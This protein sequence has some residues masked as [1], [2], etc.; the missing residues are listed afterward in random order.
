[1]KSKKWTDEKKK[2]VIMDNR[3]KSM[4]KN[5]FPAPL[6]FSI[7]DLLKDPKIADKYSKDKNSCPLLQWRKMLCGPQQLHYSY[8]TWDLRISTGI[9]TAYPTG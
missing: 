5:I 1:M 7:D 2:F 4:R 6:S 9:E 3:E 8:S